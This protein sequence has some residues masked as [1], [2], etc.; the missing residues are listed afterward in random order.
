MNKNLRHNSKTSTE[1]RN[2]LIERGTS[3]MELDPS[4]VTDW[5]RRQT[6]NKFYFLEQ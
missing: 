6:N 5:M 4:I 1:S 2:E 3:K